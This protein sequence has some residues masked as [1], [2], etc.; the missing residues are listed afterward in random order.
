MTAEP[1]SSDATSK[2]ETARMLQRLAVLACFIVFASELAAQSEEAETRPTERADEV[3]TE[4]DADRI[5]ARRTGGNVLIVDAT[6]LPASRA[7]IERGWILVQGGKIREIGV[8]DRPPGPIPEGVTLIDGKGKY[9]MPGIVDC[10]SHLAIAG[11]FNEGT[12]SISAECRIKDV[13]DPTDVNIYRAL[14]GGLTTA[15]LLHGSA[16]VIGGQDAV[17]KLKWGKSARGMLVAD[18]PQGIKFAL[19][20][21]PKRSTSRYP[22]TRLGVEAVLRRAFEE[23]KIYG[24]AWDEYAHSVQS[25][26]ADAVP[27]RR[28]LRLDALVGVMKGEIL[29]HSHCYRAD[30]ILMLMR[31]AEDYGFRVATLQHVLEGYKIGPE[32]ARHGAACSTFS[33][34]WAYKVEAYDAVPQNAALLERFGISV[35]LNSDSAELDRRLALESAKAMKYGGVSADAALRMVT[36]NPA[37]QLRIAPRVGSL[38]IG[39]DGDLAVFDGHPMSVYSKCVL[40]FIEG[41]LYFESRRAEPPAPEAVAAFAPVYA[42]KL[43][44]PIVSRGVIAVVGGTIYPVSKALIEGG[45]LVMKDGFITAVGGPDTPVPAGAVVVDA[46]GLR[47]YPGM[48]DAG[49]TLGIN[50]IGSVAETIDVDEMGRIQPDLAAAIAVNPDSEH[51]PVAR[52]NGVTQAVIAPNGGLVSGYASLIRLDGWTS[53]EMTA[54]ARLGLSINFPSNARRGSGLAHDEAASGCNCDGSGAPE[55]LDESTPAG[56]GRRDATAL[57]GLRDLLKEAR[58][59]DRR[60]REL[61]GSR[62][63]PRDLRLEALLPIVRGEKPVV[64]DVASAEDIR[65]AVDFGEQEKLRI[66]LRGA[67]DAWK[68]APYL[69]EKK[70]PVIFG[71]VLALPRE[72]FDPYDAPFATAAVLAAAG[73]PFCLQTGAASDVRNLPYQAGMAAAYGLGREAALRAVTLSAA[74]ILGVGALH[75]S[76]DVGKVADLVLTDGDILEIRTQ[77]RRL[78]IAGRESSLETRHTRFYEKYKRRLPDRTEPG[79]AR[80]QP[81][82]AQSGR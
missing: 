72:R 33:D 73:V 82:G 55:P 3:R 23:A 49:T 18:A 26:Q 37:E 1:K 19:G 80:A 69:A 44:R 32:I 29:V 62:S 48:I 30:E 41:E 12:T 53:E 21:N 74:E 6:I 15:H 4:V 10:H 56:G 16:N 54:V 31:V 67:A 35:S 47:V 78:F 34:W 81:G 63:S 66:I 65:A 7:A 64:L 75:G 11:G 42:A 39:K 9:V 17:V 58:D 40:T 51:F 45:V 24:A 14:A 13:I 52:A 46:K 2:Q 28:D 76:L 38:D 25:G 20:E 22:N 5:P 57:K 68:V 36:V 59:Y 71:P 27:P 43:D 79:D 60:G 50:E 8:G 77:V 61:S 70:V